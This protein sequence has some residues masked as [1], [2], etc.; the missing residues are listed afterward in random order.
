MLRSIS[1]LHRNLEVITLV[2]KRSNV[3][4]G[5]FRITVGQS[6]HGDGRR[7]A[8]NDVTRSDTMREEFLRA[9]TPV[10]VVSGEVILAQVLLP[11]WLWS[12]EKV[13][14]ILFFIFFI[15]KTYYPAIHHS[16]LGSAVRA[17]E[18]RSEA[19]K[20]TL[21]HRL[22]TLIEVRKPTAHSFP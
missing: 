15:T 3:K 2:N 22:S 20:Q 6:K 12:N 8:Q 19:E 9:C 1:V 10:R 13:K 21:Q 4:R 16:G 14:K 18:V 17:G 7:N 11:W 5:M